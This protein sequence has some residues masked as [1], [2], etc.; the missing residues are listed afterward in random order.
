[1]K[2]FISMASKIGLA[3]LVSLFSSGLLTSAVAYGTNNNHNGNNAGGGNIDCPANT[4]LLAKYN[5]DASTASY[6]AESGAADVTVTGNPGAGTFTVVKANTTVSAVV[7]K[8]SGDAKVVTYANVTSGSFDNN[9]LQNNG[10]NTPAISNVKICGSTTPVVP[11]TVVECSVYSS[12]VISESDMQG[13]TTTETQANGHWKFVTDGLRIYT[14]DNSSLAKVAWY[15]AVDFSLQDGGTPDLEYS[16]NPDPAV[17]G[18]QLVIDF[19]NDGTTD[20]ILV[21]EPVYGND[22]W[23]T[24]NSAQFVKDGAPS[25]TGG[26]GSANHGTLDQWLANFPDAHVK[27]IGFS[28]GSGVKGDGVIKSMTFGC[29]K[30]TFKKEVKE[31]NIVASAICSINGVTVT[32]TNNGN[33]TGTATV[34]GQ[35][36]TLL[37]GETKEVTIAVDANYSAAVKVDFKG[38]TIYEATVT[39]NPGHGGGTPQTPQT[40]QT[41]GT[42]TTSQTQLPATIPATGS[43]ESRNPLMIVLAAL[44]AYGA[45][46][47]L[48]GRI[49]LARKRS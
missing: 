8:G 24:N 44:V 36:V 49:D 20:G 11:P 21:G 3:L 42:S 37:A 2:R 17:P 16:A 14:D 15:K 28:L 23:L 32:L 38:T 41:L 13:F 35:D 4:T 29:V 22:W 7:V 19:D 39:C 47:F 43:T 45:A 27:F 18:K 46:Y 1:M 6:I 25:H 12:V 5:W 34:N 30:Y 40:P 31:A 48:Q 26:S 10:G 33:A 9:G